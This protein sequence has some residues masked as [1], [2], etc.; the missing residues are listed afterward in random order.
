MAEEKKH[1]DAEKNEEEKGQEGLLD[2]QKDE[3]EE[4][5]VADL[6]G[7]DSDGSG[8]KDEQGE[9]D[10]KGSIE[11][12]LPEEYEGDENLVAFAKENGLT[13]DQ[14]DN[15]LKY[16]KQQEQAAEEAYSTLM[17]EETKKLQ[18]EWGTRYG[19]R[20]KTAKSAVKM[21]DKEVPG[22][23]QF[24]R[25]S[26]AAT[27]PHVIRIMEAVGRLLAGKSAEKPSEKK[28]EKE[29]PEKSNKPKQKKKKT[30]WDTPAVER[31]YP[32]E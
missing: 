17:K 27:N 7:E 16:L 5:D 3:K 10:E 15:S 25:D 1:E 31:L 28:T 18:G 26:K 29:A 20:L 21:L 6:L 13:Q 23:V 14:L 24:L 32:K 8:E 22:M 11:Y 9:K 12:K 30:G 19:E 2:D 4:Q